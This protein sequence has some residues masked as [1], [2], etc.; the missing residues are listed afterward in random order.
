MADLKVVTREDADA[1]D[2]LIL[3]RLAELLVQ[4]E[5]ARETRGL[6]I[7]E[8][9]AI[10][11]A[12]TDAKGAVVVDEERTGV[13]PRDAAAEFFDRSGYP[14][15]GEFLRDR[16][17]PGFLAVVAELDGNVTGRFVKPMSLEAKGQ[18]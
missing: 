8:M 17:R 3:D 6:S 12:K 7:D 9:A 4:C 16:A 18:A 11:V 1:Y 5:R 15:F 10:I 13:L 14:T 2:E